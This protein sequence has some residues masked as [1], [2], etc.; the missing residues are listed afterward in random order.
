MIGKLKRLPDT[1]QETVQERGCWGNGAESGSLALVH[2]KSE[3]EIHTALW[4]AAR[5]G[6]I[7][8]QDGSYLFLHDRVQEAAYALIPEGER[9]VTHLAIG[10][11]LASLTAPE[12]L[13]E[14]IFDIV[15][16]FNHGAA[17]LIDRDEKS[18]VATLDLR[19]GRKAKAPTAYASAPE[20]FSAA[21]SLLD[22]RD[23]SSQYDLTFS[24]WLEP[25][26]WEPLTGN[27]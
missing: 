26:A 9:A 19:P 10:R 6:L 3:R 22:E 17:L 23:W 4:E 1:T 25:A 11:L 27:F 24:L 21:M 13:E 20:Y 8:R 18:Q 7:F 12:E 2:G 14:K 5:T 15:N 16:Q